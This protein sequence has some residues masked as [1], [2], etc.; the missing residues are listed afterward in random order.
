MS[1]HTRGNHLF[2][3]IL[4]MWTDKVCHSPERILDCFTQNLGF[5]VDLIHDVFPTRANLDDMLAELPSDP[6]DSSLGVLDPLLA[7]SSLVSQSHPPP[8]DA[9]GFSTYGRAVFAVLL[10]FTGN[11]QLARHN[12]WALRHLLALA[13]YADDVTQVS[14]GVSPLFG[15]VSP[16]ELEEI[17]NGVQQMTTYLLGS[18]TDEGFHERV[19]AA[20]SDGKKD[21]ADGLEAFLVEVVEKSKIEEGAR[22]CRVLFRVLHH[23]LA[24]ASKEEADYWLAF[25]RKLDKTGTCH[26][27][28]LLDF[29][30]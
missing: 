28:F 27:A 12:L 2:V 14:L 16:S 24:N 19:I 3:R 30:F 18:A 23:F 13:I 20:L 4:Y 10:A 8:C 9:R 1:L 21:V 5:E 6:I 26:R 22:G 15:M 11:R 29:T 7:Y 25:A 17:V